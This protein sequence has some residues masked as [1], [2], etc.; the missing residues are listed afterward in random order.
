MAKL[1]VCWVVR[2]Y[3]SSKED[4][5]AMGLKPS[6]EVYQVCDGGE[7]LYFTELLFPLLEKCQ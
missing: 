4:V 3:G 2:W 1:A 5:G 7:F 6:A